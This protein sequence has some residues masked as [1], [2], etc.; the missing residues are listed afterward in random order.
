M[1]TKKGETRP[2]CQWKDH[3]WKTNFFFIAGT[4]V[5]RIYVCSK[6][7]RLKT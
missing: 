5:Q 1:L 2:K 6:C 3:S 4:R 7:N